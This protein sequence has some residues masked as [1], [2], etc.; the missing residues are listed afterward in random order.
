MN[1]FGI[2][3]PFTKRASPSVQ[4][5]RWFTPSPLVFLTDGTLVTP[6]TALRMSAVFGCVRVISQTLAALPLLVY[7]RQ[8]D[9]GKDRATKH[10]LYKL[11]RTRPNRFKT[12]GLEFREMLT[13]HALLYGN[14]YAQIIRNRLGEPLELVPLHPTRTRPDVTE[15]NELVYRVRQSAGA[16]RVLPGDQVFHIRAFRDAGL[17]GISPI[18]A[19]EKAI[20]AGLSLE[21]YGMNFF[22]GGAVPGGVLKYPGEMSEQAKKNLRDSW[23][24][25]HGGENRGRKTAVL[26]GGVEFQQAQIPQTDA[27]FL[28]QRKFQVTEICRIYGVPPHLLADLDRAT[29]SNIEEQNQNFI[30]YCLLPW[31]RRWEEA[32]TRDLMDGDDSK[33]FAEFLVDGLLRG[34]ITARGQFYAL[35][36]THGWFSINDVRKKENLNPIGPDGDI[37]LSPMN[38]VPAGEE[39][40]QQE[41]SQPAEEPNDGDEDEDRG[42]APEGQASDRLPGGAQA[43]EEKLKG[44]FRGA[45]RETWARVVRKEVNAVKTAARKRGDEF[46]PWFDEFLADHRSFAAECLREIAR[47]Y[48]VLRGFDVDALVPGLV[49]E[50]RAAVRDA[51]DAWRAEPGRGYDRREDE[52]AAYWTERLLGYSGGSYEC[53]A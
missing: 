49:D 13:G 5:D 30:D 2:H 37:Y 31:F 27:Q 40:Q 23:E 39:G 48:C 4:D 20:R 24:R 41:P 21:S 32:I 38:M 47:S 15:A 33:Y 43:E 34:N 46:D 36:R 7:E 25:L 8:A 35:G 22:E 42:Q 44:A 53:A 26:E 19:A 18:A 1:I 14:G 6:E 12:S 9:G 45:F 3:V 50:Y 10:P 17:E 11:L 29:F 16:E 51:V 52:V 28:E